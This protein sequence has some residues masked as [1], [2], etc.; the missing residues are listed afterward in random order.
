MKT[1][2][3]QSLPLGAEKG[4]FVRLYQAVIFRA[5]Q[6]LARKRHH[7][8]A[9]RW[10]LSPESDYAFATAGISPDAIRQPVAEINKRT[11]LNQ[12][13]LRQAITN[14]SAARIGAY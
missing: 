2:S 1:T 6:D 14:F 3:S 7:A 5:V 4:P 9:R 8:D 12:R 13:V 11:K 10:L